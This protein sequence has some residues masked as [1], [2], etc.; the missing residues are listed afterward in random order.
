[1]AQLR[2]HL[3]GAPRCE[4]EGRAVEFTRRK[5]LALLAYLAVTAQPHDRDA[6]ATLFWPEYDQAS[7][8]ANLRR[9]LSQLKEALGDEMLDVSR[10]QIALNPQADIWLDVSEFQRLLAAVD[11][12]GHA[13]QAL[14]AGCLDALTTAAELYGHDFMAGFSLP[15]CPEFDEWQFFLSDGLRQSLARMLQT[16]VEW[17]GAHED[18]ERGIDYA[19]R[20]VA[21]DSWHEPAH[22]RLMQLYAMAGQP[23]AALRQ[24]DTLVRM[25][26]AEFVVEP[27]PETTELYNAIKSRRSVASSA[28]PIPAPTGAGEPGALPASTQADTGAQRADAPRHNLPAQMMPFVGRRKE[29][30]EITN[31][32][33]DGA[34]QPL[35]SLVGPG[36]IGKTRLA[37]QTGREVLGR[38]RDGVCFVPL[39]GLASSD[40]VVPLLAEKL[41]LRFY[42][43]KDARQQLLDFLQPKQMLLIL[44]NFEHLLDGVDL[45]REM[46]Q[47]A[48]G[49]RILV[50]SRE[51]LN[52]S[53]ELIYVIGG[54]DF[55]QHDSVESLLD[56]DAAELLVQAAR[57]S[58]PGFEVDDGNIGDVIRICRLVEGM[59]LALVLAAGWLGVLSLV[60]IAQ[61]ITASLDFL[62]TEL[63]DVPERQRSV[64]AAFE[65]SWKRLS[66]DE[67]RVFMKLCVFRGGFTRHAAEAVAGARLPVLRTLV[68]RSFVSAAGDGRFVIHELLRQYGLLYA[69]QDP[70]DYE[71]TRLNHSAYYVAFLHERAVVIKEHHQRETLAGIAADIDNVRMAWDH[72]VACHDWDALDPVVECYWLFSEFRGALSAGEAAFR[73]AL[74]ALLESGA[75][76]DAGP[77]ADRA[78]LAGFLLAAAGCL[79]AR[80]GRFEDGVADMHAGIAWIRRAD[81]PDHRKEAFALAWLAFVLV[82]QG[83]YDG[84]RTYAEESLSWFPETGDRWLKAGCLRLIGASELYRGRLDDAEQA[85]RSCLGVCQEIGERRIRTYATANLGLIAML[86]GS[87]AEAGRLLDEA[88]ETSYVLDDLLSRAEVLREKVRLALLLG[89]DARAADYVEHSMAIYQKI[90][91]SDTG[92]V[93]CVLGDIHRAQ[94]DTAAAEQL[95]RESLDQSQAVNHQP[96]V[97]RCLSQWGMLEYAR[98]A[99]GPAE[100]HLCSALAIWQQAGNEVEIASVQRHLG[101]ILAAS[102]DERQAEAGRHYAEALDLALRHQLAPVAL[103]VLVGSAA[104]LRHTMTAGE[105]IALLA[106]A[107]DHP[108]SAFETRGRA[109]A[110]LAEFAP[111]GDDRAEATAPPDAPSQDWTRAAAQ[112]AESFRQYAG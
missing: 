9:T 36:G 52:I 29:L 72:A 96:E 11:A 97:A 7:A 15:D 27:T 112:L 99:Y 56:Y 49:I 42:P 43:G 84:A 53:G 81:K 59:P 104:H 107:R 37:I 23:S 61:E 90:G 55:P 3:F 10:M 92:A 95:Y 82:V 77:P 57:L 48:P 13:P 105:A 39:A 14:C 110:L 100:A 45:V 78:G 74:A 40:Y 73:H 21:L 31:L 54:M 94:G 1:M 68:N 71:R 2:I 4:S 64:R 26:D 69:Q 30:F 8:R 101:H 24:Y 5:T 6:L 17:H 86:R 28:G 22:A 88:L 70:A 38:F 85:L 19:R 58:Y 60:E 93:L 108:A 20:Q 50:T 67:Q 32:L 98:E 12:H 41:E 16:L 44:D 63:R 79:R 106:L 51:R 35:I 87:Y 76:T 65:Y 109:A 91:R 25:L 89:D 33:L 34:E 83:R 111:G 102:G 80:Q 47:A 46:L 103:D 66:A 75:P 18:Y 62:E